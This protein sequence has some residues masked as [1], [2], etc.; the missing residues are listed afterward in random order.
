M[1]ILI[2]LDEATY[3][4]LEKVAPA[5]SRKR[6]AFVRAAIQKSLW[7]LEEER[8]RQA[9]LQTPDDDPPAFD[10][11]VWEPLPYG[12]FDPPA[13]DPRAQVLPSGLEKRRARTSRRARSKKTSSRA[14][15]K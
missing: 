3:R 7:E 2:E 13:L 6:S 15:H 8:T 1:N 12:G 11:W 14:S 5:K 9:Y 4:R 10:P